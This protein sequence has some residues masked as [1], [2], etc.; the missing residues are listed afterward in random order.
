MGG[1]LRRFY[2]RRNFVRQCSRVNLA[3]SPLKT[4]LLGVLKGVN[5]GAHAGRPVSI[6][7][8][9]SGYIR[10]YRPPTSRSIRPRPSVPAAPLPPNTSARVTVELAAHSPS[11]FAAR[12]HLELWDI[13]LITELRL[14]NAASPELPRS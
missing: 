1:Y 3:D 7:A 14:N 10:A 2:R 4:E 8:N 13:Y 9:G 11:Y 5:F 12:I 6:Y